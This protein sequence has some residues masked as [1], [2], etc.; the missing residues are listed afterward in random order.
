MTYEQLIEAANAAGYRLIPKDP[1]CGPRLS[2]PRCGR[3]GR[4][5]T[6]YNSRYVTQRTH[7]IVRCECGFES[8][9]FE[10]LRGRHE[11]Q[12][13]DAAWNDAVKA[14]MERK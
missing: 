14:V 11:E 6:V 7:G 8:R 4:T 2:C 12:W 13:A 10:F 9:Q 1:P 3:F 5:Y